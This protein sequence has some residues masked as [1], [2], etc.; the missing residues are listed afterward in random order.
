MVAITASVHKLNFRPE[1]G[2]T[3]GWSV[4]ENV[5]TD[6]EGWFDPG[7]RRRAANETVGFPGRICMM[8]F[9]PRSL[10]NLF[11]AL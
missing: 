2:E 1:E 5:V 9:L 11:Y 4:I 6:A 8:I 10:N 7:Y 3:G